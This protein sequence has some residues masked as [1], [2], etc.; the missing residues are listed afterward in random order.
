ML[1]TSIATLVRSLSSGLLEYFSCRSVDTWKP[2]AWVSCTISIASSR[3]LKH[4]C[5]GGSPWLPGEEIPVSHGSYFWYA[6]NEG[7]LAPNNS[8][9]VSV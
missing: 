9:I 2:R 4:R 6:H 1:S 7:L 3:Q 8:N 5:Q